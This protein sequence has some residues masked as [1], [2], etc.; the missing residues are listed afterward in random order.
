M[1]SWGW[2]CSAGV[3]GAHPAP[4]VAPEPSKTLPL[5]HCPHDARSPPNWALTPRLVVVAKGGGCARLFGAIVPWWQH[6][7]TPGTPASSLSRSGTGSSALP[8]LSPSGCAAFSAPPPPGKQPRG[9]KDVPSSVA[10]AAAC[11]TCVPLGWGPPQP[12]GHGFY[13][14]SVASHSQGVSVTCCLA[15][16]PAHDEPIHRRSQGA[17]RARLPRGEG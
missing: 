2:Q 6:R 3:P 17:H 10:G 7:C 16:A 12:R 8:M 9:S 4:C 15:S 5:G 1:L 11:S 14:I 13:G